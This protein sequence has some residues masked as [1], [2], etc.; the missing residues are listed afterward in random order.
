M[1]PPTIPAP[2]PVPEHGPVHPEIGWAD[3]SLAGRRL[4]VW[5]MALRDVMAPVEDSPGLVA[6]M[7]LRSAVTIHA[8]PSAPP[9]PPQAVEPLVALW[10]ALTR[11]G[12]DDPADG[13]APG[14]DAHAR[15]DDGWHLMLGALVAA[16]HSRRD[17]L[18][19]RQPGAPYDGWSLPQARWWARAARRLRDLDSRMAV[20]NTADGAAL[21]AGTPE[22]K[23]TV[24]RRLEAL[25]RG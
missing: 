11:R 17:M 24:A 19:A 22:S 23:A 8:M 2:P 13:P 14:S 6:G 15:A 25:T 5:P 3:M 9:L 12:E 7:A 4:R 21:F 20:E 1:R 10:L 18:D 16:G